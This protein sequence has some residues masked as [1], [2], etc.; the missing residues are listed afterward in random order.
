MPAYW[1][2]KMQLLAT[3]QPTHDR[4]DLTALCHCHASISGS[5]EIC[6]ASAAG[7]SSARGLQIQRAFAQIEFPHAF[8]AEV[9]CAGQG[10]GVQGCRK[11]CSSL[12]RCR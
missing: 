10:A 7:S 12:Q 2:Q 6:S 8:A 3:S 1:T 4:G 5:A 11:A 9:V